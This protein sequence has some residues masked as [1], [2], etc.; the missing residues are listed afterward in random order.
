MTLLGPLNSQSPLRIGGD[1]FDGVI[2]EVILLRRYMPEE[3]YIEIYN[4]G[5]PYGETIDH[6]IPYP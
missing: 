3:E 6:L 2:D 1:N 4:V 5:N